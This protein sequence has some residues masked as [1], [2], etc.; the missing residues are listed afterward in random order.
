MTRIDDKIVEIE[1]YLE[2]LYKIF[3][4]NFEEYKQN[5]EKRLACER[6]FEKIIGAIMD[7]AFI[8]IKEKSFKIPE[9]EKESFDILSKENIITEELSNKLQDAKSMRNLIVHEYGKIDDQLVFEAIRDELYGDIQN[10]IK[11]IKEK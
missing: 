2:E 11:K 10:F 7:L 5:M 8:I 3:P 9:V 6:L 1:N 4:D